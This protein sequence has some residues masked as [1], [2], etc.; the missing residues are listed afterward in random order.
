MKRFSIST[1]LLGLMLS[2]VLPFVLFFAFL[3]NQLHNSENAALER[4]VVR[5]ADAV[6][7]AVQPAL[8]EMVTT[9]NLVAPTEEL[10]AGDFEAFHDR[11]VSA[12]GDSGN[13][14]LVVDG[15]G[16]QL[17]NTRVPFGTELG[18]TSNTAALEDSLKLGTIY[19]SD[20]FEGRTSGEWVFNVI[21]PLEEQQR[22]SARAVITT[23]NARDLAFAFDGLELPVN[24]NAAIVDQNGR[25][26]AAHGSRQIETGS[27]LMLTD[28]VGVLDFDLVR[29]FERFDANGTPNIAGFTVIYPSG[30]QAVVW[31]PSGTAQALLLSA[32]RQLILGAL[33]FLA[34]GIGILYS[35]ARALNLTIQRIAEMASRLGEGEI[36]SPVTTRVIELDKTAKALSEASFDRAQREETLQVVMRE[37]AHRTKNLMSVVLSMVR[38]SSRQASDV[39]SMT[40]ALSQRILGLGKSIDLLTQRDWRR[41]PLIDLAREQTTG[42]SEASVHFFGPAILLRAEAVQHLGMA[43]HELSTNAV[44]HGAM[45]KPGGRV[46][47]TWKTVPVDGT[48]Q[49]EIE[50]KET[51]GPKAADM[52][53]KGF[54]SQILER[55]AAAALNGT[56]E[57]E[58]AD[59][60]LIWRL[61]APLEQ[62][63]G[64][65]DAAAR[66]AGPDS[67]TPQARG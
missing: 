66:T 46:D 37:L 54:G 35:V 26:A 39:D 29:G 12:L 50:W 56:S 60:G 11:M 28:G 7:V 45:K 67:D 23:K 43:L 53:K 42:F 64:P 10:V 6:K 44:K 63:T 21:K 14:I 65:A 36:V 59:A 57:I 8:A 31:G 13:F 61:K 3:L 52:E 62:L 27:L 1:L 20:V 33:L 47:L 30:W 51:G 16:Q 58:Y 18:K 19:V 9:L 55:F 25:V 5:S 34:I 15:Q 40:E 17:L 32:W 49:F 48:E 24:W 4:D 41:V 38:L 22:S 2:A